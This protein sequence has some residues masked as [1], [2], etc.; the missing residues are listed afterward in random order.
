M[1]RRPKRWVYDPPQPPKPKVPEELKAR[2]QAQADALVESVLKPEYIK[3][4]PQ[5]K[6]FNYLVDLFT[7]WHRSFFYFCSQYCSPGPRALSPFFESRF[8]R[9]EY[10]GGERFNLAYMRHT[11]KWGEI[12]TDLSLEECLEAIWDQPF[13][14]P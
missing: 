14:H 5:E 6:R 11:G 9:L 4:P 3:P 10:V 1:A 12:F 7:K 2:V 8:A 13:F